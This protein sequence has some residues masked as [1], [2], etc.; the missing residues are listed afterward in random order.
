MIIIKM[1]H[2]YV[3]PSKLIVK[4]IDINVL[5]AK[6]LSRMNKNTSHTQL[7]IMKDLPA[8]IFR[9]VSGKNNRE[10]LLFKSNRHNKPNNIIGISRFSRRSFF[11]LHIYTHTPRI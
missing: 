5:S 3:L 11:R 6:S 8:E 9:S 4:V 1:R 10:K 7:Y 2:S